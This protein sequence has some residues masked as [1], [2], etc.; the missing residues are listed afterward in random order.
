MGTKVTEMLMAVSNRDKQVQMALK[1]VLEC[2]EQ[3]RE[4]RMDE[5]YIQAR[6]LQV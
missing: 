2:M 1:S 3:E 4:L 5:D 6:P